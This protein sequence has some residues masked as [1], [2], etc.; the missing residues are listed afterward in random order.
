MQMLDVPGRVIARAACGPYVR[1]WAWGRTRA[2]PPRAGNRQRTAR[3]SHP[4]QPV[5][6]VAQPHRSPLTYEVGEGTMKKK[7]VLRRGSGRCSQR[8]SNRLLK[9]RIIS[10]CR[11]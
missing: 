7:L 2:E 9:K 6:A 10:K 11:Q 8:R 4:H 3:A 5:P 1:A